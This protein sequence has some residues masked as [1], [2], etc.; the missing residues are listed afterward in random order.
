M[1]FYIETVI[2]RR[3]LTR[4][5]MKINREEWSFYRRVYRRLNMTIE[6]C[7]SYY[8]NRKDDKTEYGYEIFP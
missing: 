7:C 3:L 6:R 1:F 4:E 5:T 8:S 2:R